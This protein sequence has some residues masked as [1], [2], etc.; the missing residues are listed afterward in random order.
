MTNKHDSRF[1]Q[2]YY[3]EYVLRLHKSSRDKTISDASVVKAYWRPTLN[4]WWSVWRRQ[5]LPVRLTHTVQP[6]WPCLR[7]LHR[8]MSHKQ[9]A[10][11]CDVEI[12]ACH[13]ESVSNDIVEIKRIIDIR[14]NKIKEDSNVV[15]S[16]RDNAPLCV[17]V[18]DP[19]PKPND[20]EDGGVNEAQP[21]T[22]TPS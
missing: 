10:S 8:P 22:S 4:F 1:H 12:D 14:K 19:Q 17:C 21:P 7:R 13:R 20:D 16:Q 18:A 3:V 6:P 2:F 9:T 15:I 5:L 11:H